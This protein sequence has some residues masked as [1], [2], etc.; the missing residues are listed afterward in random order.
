MLL[1]ESLPESK[2]SLFHASVNQLPCTRGWA[3]VLESSKS[4]C[5]GS[6]GQGILAGTQPLAQLPG[7]PT[8]LL[9]IETFDGINM[10]L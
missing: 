6:R 1:R 5:L 9:S 7:Q 3:V 8:C 2:S 10:F 4:S